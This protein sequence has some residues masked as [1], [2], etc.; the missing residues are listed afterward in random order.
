MSAI[1]IIGPAF[2]L[3]GG[4]AAFNERLAAELGAMGHEVILYS[5]S[6]QYPALLFPGKT[7]YREGPPPP[8][9]DIRTRINAIHPFNWWSVGRELRRLQPDMVITRFW[10]PFTGLSLGAVLRRFRRGSRSPVVCIAD[11]VVPHEHRPGDRLLTRYF[12]GACD[13]FV[14]MSSPVLR[15]LR[16]FTD[17]PVA[18]VPHPLYDHF[19]PAMP[20]AEARRRLGLD[21]GGK[22]LLFFGFIRRYKGLDL[23]LQAMARPALA[24]AGVRL[25]VAGEF[26]EDPAPYLDYIQREGLASRVILHDRFIPDAQVGAYF[27]AADAVV[28]PYR[29]ATQSGIT[30]MAY[31]YERPMIVTRTGGLPEMVAD[32][33]TGLLCDPDPGAIAEA[34]MTFYAGDPDRFLAALRNHKEKYS[35]RRMAESL[36]ALGRGEKP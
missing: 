21:D 33:E 8:G 9:L 31:H 24:A 11:N 3:R 32:G 26:Y 13:A 28:Q 30:P 4:I 6:L 34:V 2:P 20:R 29:S 7:Q 14:A 17:K 10:L 5:F 1:V 19:G 22:V 27:C 12:L 36:L 35:W 23:L 16:R 25:L 15:D 18:Q